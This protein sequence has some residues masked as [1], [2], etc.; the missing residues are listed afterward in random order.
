[1]IDGILRDHPKPKQAERNP[2][3]VLQ[4]DSGFDERYL[5]YED[6]VLPRFARE[7]H[8]YLEVFYGQVPFSLIVENVSDIRA[9]NLIIDV[10]VAGGWINA[11]PVVLP[12][13][14]PPPPRI[15]GWDP[16]RNMRFDQFAKPDVGRHEFTDNVAPRCDS[17]SVQCEDFRHGHQW[18]FTG[19]VWLDPGYERDT[20]VY[21]KVTAANFRGECTAHLRM[22]KAIQ[23]ANP[24][25]LI[26]LRTGILK[27]QSHIQPV[28]DMAI[29]TKNLKLVEFDSET[30][31]RGGGS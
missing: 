18:V 3:D 15:E 20:V 11:K 5:N 17:F 27:V 19:V 8:R 13:R 12:R 4:H 14:G 22:Q 21:A 26:D 25:D 28:I 16:M 24:N 10:N 23:K 2:L 6:K 7:F 9:D 1:M 29:K 30:F 31:H